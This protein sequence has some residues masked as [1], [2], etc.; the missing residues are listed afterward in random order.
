VRF[1]S[2]LFRRSQESARYRIKITTEDGTVVYWHKND[3]VH[4][5]EEDVATIFVQRF[6]PQL[7]EVL[8]NGSF[9]SPIA[10]TTM[11]VRKLE[12]ERI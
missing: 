12:M 1:L 11:R 10:G 2:R 7:F 9:S 5:V 4:V 6:K 8:P 3:Q